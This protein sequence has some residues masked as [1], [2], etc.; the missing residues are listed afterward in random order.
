[1]T[2]AEHQTGQNKLE[3]SYVQMMRELRGVRRSVPAAVLLQELSEL[4]LAV[5]WKRQAL[6]FWSAL[7]A[8]TETYIFKQAG[9]DDLAAVQQSK[10][11]SWAFGMCAAAWHEQRDAALMRS[12]RAQRNVR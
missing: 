7:T 12:L 9:M 8:L 2:L 3:A 4:L 1:M 10:K 6:R 11:Q 5:E